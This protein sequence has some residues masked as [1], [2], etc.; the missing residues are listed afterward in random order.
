MKIRIVS[1]LH[2][3]FNPH[4]LNSFSTLPG[5]DMLILAGDI[6]QFSNIGLLKLFI[7]S[8]RN[9]YRYI[10]YVL[11]NHEY[12]G[13]SAETMVE[14]VFRKVC[15]ELGIILLENETITLNDEI[16][17][18]GTTLW[19]P[20]KTAD[21]YSDIQQAFILE[22]NRKA[23]EFIKKT[24]ADVIITHHLPDLRFVDEKYGDPHGAY[25]NK[26]F[27]KRNLNCKYWIFGHTHRFVRE[28]NCGNGTKVEFICNPHGYPGEL[29]PQDIVVDIN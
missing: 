12:Y 26:W 9:N 19:S 22:K 29:K 24:P 11:G 3:E 5:V 17:F 28:R 6:V 23:I 21:Y 14:P 25:A 15:N 18:L 10:L 20:L 27:L 4:L 2:L 8:I 7:E 16:T 13:N 1:D